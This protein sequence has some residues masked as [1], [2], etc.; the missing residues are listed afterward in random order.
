[1]TKKRKRRTSRKLGN[2][3]KLI[4]AIF[5]L[6]LFVLIFGLLPIKV[7]WII[8]GITGG[9]SLIAVLF[10]FLK[11]KTIKKGVSNRLGI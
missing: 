7:W 11:I 1:M 6:S 10:H 2:F 5:L 9:I 8:T 4:F 3:I